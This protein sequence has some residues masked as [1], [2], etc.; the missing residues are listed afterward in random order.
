VRQ[1]KVGSQEGKRGNLLKFCVKLEGGYPRW[2][3]TSGAA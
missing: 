3:K 1:E 2:K